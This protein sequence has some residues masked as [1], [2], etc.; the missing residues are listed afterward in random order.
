MQ[1]NAFDAKYFSSGACSWSGACKAQ[2]ATSSKRAPCAFEFLVTD[3]ADR[4]QD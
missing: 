2:L 1:A 3:L 4:A